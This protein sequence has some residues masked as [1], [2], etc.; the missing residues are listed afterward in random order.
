MAGDLVQVYE[1]HGFVRLVDWVGDELSVV[2]AARVSLHKASEYEADGSLGE[3]DKGLIRFLLKNKHGT[4]FEQ[5]FM[6][7]FNIRV[8]IF[9]MRE[10]IRH[11]VGFCLSGDTEVW[12]ET[13]A[14]KSGRT[15]R[16]R[17]IKDLYENWHNG[18][19]DNLGRTRLLPSCRNL[20]MRVLN[21][22][23]QLFELG[24]MIDIVKS[25]SKPLL[26]IKTVSGHTLNCS[27]DHR[28]L[29]KRGWVTAGEL[30]LET[31]EIA[32]VG[33]RNKN[34]RTISN[35]LRS[36]IGSWTVQQRERLIHPTD[37]CYICERDFSR[38]D[39]VLDHIVPVMADLSK[40][41]D[42]KNLA[43]ACIEC[44]REKT[45]DEQ[46]VEREIV[47]GSKYVPLASIRQRAGTEP[48]YDIVMD[49]PWHNFV[50]NGIVVHNSYNEES[51]RYVELRPDFFIPEEVRTQQG[52]PG[53]YHFERIEDRGVE[54][55]FK[56]MLKYHS[57][58]GYDL[59]K[60]A[61]EYGIAKEQAR[62]F[63]GLNLYTEFLWTC[64]ARS[65]MNFLALRNDPPAMQEIRTYAGAIEK[66]FAEKMPVTHAAFE[67]AG[68]VAP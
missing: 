41:L 22:E 18:V 55:W 30:D 11:R 12:C 34:K 25:G 13:I 4:P 7:Q 23:T 40:A 33:K 44:H 52:K 24:T 19:Q 36:A 42:D 14:P 56:G 16:K 61:L 5:G 45:N 51:G 57:E 28:I 65:L 58:K 46:S 29:A 38:N 53:N 67:D 21:E 17:K 54:E 8:P 27:K 47:A 9:V 48:T 1:P 31:D 3:K 49:D 32:V 50:A 68:R 37:W 43:P 63:L 26:E 6:A 60:E 35:H 2:N 20:S 66:I 10:W 62:L 15:V 39:L 64:N 59:Y